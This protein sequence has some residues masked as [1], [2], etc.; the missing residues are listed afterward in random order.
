MVKIEKTFSFSSC[1]LQYL[2]PVL[3]NGAV[4]ASEG[5]TCIPQIFSP[6]FLLFLSPSYPSN[7]NAKVILNSHKMIP[8]LLPLAI[9][10]VSQH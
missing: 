8:P 2:V 6:G 10:F 5:T 3:S 4:Q 7:I 9:V 1:A